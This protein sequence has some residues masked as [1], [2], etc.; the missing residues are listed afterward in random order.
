MLWAM[1]AQTWRHVF[2]MVILDRENVIGK[3]Y[4]DQNVQLYDR[5]EELLAKC[6]AAG[7][8]PEGLDL[9]PLRGLKLEQFDHPLKRN[10]Q[11]N[12][13]N[14]LVRAASWIGH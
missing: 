3:G 4:G 10:Y 5:C 1:A 11:Q 14:A 9:K 12:S 2:A 8:L 6:V 13:Q 7:N